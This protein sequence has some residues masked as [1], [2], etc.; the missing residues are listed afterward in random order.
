M[1]ANVR[2]KKTRVQRLKNDMGEWV[3]VD[4]GLANLVRGYF[5]DIFSSQATN[6]NGFLH[7]IESQVTAN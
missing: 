3:D 2:H 5:M 4:F 1:V 6:L 7:G